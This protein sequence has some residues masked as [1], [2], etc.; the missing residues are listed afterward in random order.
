MLE[1]FLEGGRSRTGKLL[2]P[3]TGLL[4]MIVDAALGVKTRSVRFVPVSIGY[5]RIVETSSYEHETSG[6]EKQKEDAAGL[7]KTTQVLRHK[8]GRITVQ[9]G[10]ALGLEGLKS[11]LGLPAEGELSAATKR[12]LVTRLAN[13]TMDE[14]NRV[15]AVTA[16]SLT[17]LAIL[18]DR[19]RSV[20]HEELIVRCEK[21]VRML[22][23]MGARSPRAPRSAASCAPIDRR[24]GD[25]VRE[26]DM[27]EVH[28]SGR[29]Q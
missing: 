13:R 3:K 5:E 27:L 21:L 12:A 11:E 9:F 17:A 22:H 29:H 2:P 28:S 1:L 20:A 8:Y 18:S 19:R 14:I 4:H 24:S 26:A 23:E 15:T 10:E 7:L 25:V 6:G 16:G